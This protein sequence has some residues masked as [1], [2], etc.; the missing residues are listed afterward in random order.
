MGFV[1]LRIIFFFEI[2]IELTEE[3]NIYGIF[4]MNNQSE[5]ALGLRF[6]RFFSS[7]Y[8]ESDGKRLRMIYE[9]VTFRTYRVTNDLDSSVTRV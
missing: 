4:W 8:E 1:S 7:M 6:L 5:A 3:R 2:E 9:Q